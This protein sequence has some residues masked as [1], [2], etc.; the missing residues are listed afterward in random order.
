MREAFANDIDIHTATAS[1]VF[2]VPI[3]AVT[4]DL[5][6]ALRTTT[7]D[8]T[9]PDDACFSYRELYRRLAAFEAETHEH[10]HLEN[11]ILFPRAIELERMVVV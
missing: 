6:R 11:N 10:I 4:R 3:D 5:L 9:L 1:N 8:Y 7:S 2:H